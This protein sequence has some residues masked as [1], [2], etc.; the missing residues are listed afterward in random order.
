[1]S[2]YP[3]ANVH[4]DAQIG[5][6]VIIEPFATIKADVVIGDGCWIGPNSIIWGLYLLHPSGLKVCR[7]ENRNFYW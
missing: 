4:P 1:M 3:L 7:R 6:D 2:K 5:N